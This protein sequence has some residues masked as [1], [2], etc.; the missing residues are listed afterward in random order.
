MK[1]KERLIDELIDLAFAEDIG[2][3]D[4]TTLCCIPDTAM[5]KSRLL[6]KE[7]GIL[8]G[9]EIARKIFHRFDPDLK[10]TVYI[11]DGTAVKPGDVA[12]V[13]EGRVQSL[14][15]TERL[16]LNVMQRMS[17]IATMT[18]RYVKKLEGLH[19]R[20]LDTRKTTPGMRM[21]EKEAVKIGGGV[22]HRIGLFDMILLKDNHVD[23]AGGIENAIS[24]C[25]DYLKAKGKD[26]KIEIEVRNLDE[27]KEVMRVGGVD[28]IMLDNF[29]PELTKEAV[30]IV[31]GKYEIESSGGITFDTIRDYAESG[32]D[33]VSVGA[34]THSVKGLDMSFKAC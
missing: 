17:G 14:L 34:L 4:H 28:R 19:T 13:V 23:F 25:H 12:F 22:N 2:D 33:F 3:G 10:M 20:I 9:V 27:L 6:I 26:L 1:T 15:Q 16:M 8:A 11:E 31:G 24:R 21:L 29:S 18:H 5:G 32:V 7:P 30:K